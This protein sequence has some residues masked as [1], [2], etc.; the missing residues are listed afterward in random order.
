MG[1]IPGLGKKAMKRPSGTVRVESPRRM[2][3]CASTE[4]GT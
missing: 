4:D 2:G 1:R 3:C